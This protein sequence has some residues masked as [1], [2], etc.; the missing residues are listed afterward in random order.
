MS[1]ASLVSLISKKIF[2]T[3]NTIYIYELIDII[4]PFMYLKL[5]KILFF[6]KSYLFNIINLL[7]FVESE[8]LF[9]TFR[10]I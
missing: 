9:F 8:S 1:I 7:K 6:N 4:N 5:C 2:Q 3:E 10:F